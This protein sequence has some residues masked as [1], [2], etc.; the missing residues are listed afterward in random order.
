MHN[1]K[2]VSHN[3]SLET[4]VNQTKII[5]QQPKSFM[6]ILDEA[7]GVFSKPKPKPVFEIIKGHL[8]HCYYNDM[9]IPQSE[10]SEEIDVTGFEHLPDAFWIGE[11]ADSIL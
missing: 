9:E 6:E 5:P 7:V 4:V 11:I 10:W 2:N 1:S 3:T 8:N